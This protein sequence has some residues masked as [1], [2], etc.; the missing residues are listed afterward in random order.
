MLNSY[1]KGQPTDTPL[2]P[3]GSTEAVAERITGRGAV[4]RLFEQRWLVLLLGLILFALAA[5]YRLPWEAEA[6]ALAAFVAGAALIPR[7]AMKQVFLP[8]IAAPP[9]VEP[10]HIAAL[11][12]DA[13]P[14]PTIL[15]SCDGTILFAN[16][17]ARDLFGGLRPGS[18][19]SSATRSPQV[20][21]AVMDCGPAEAQRTVTF[22]ER[23]PVERYMAATVSYLGGR[24]EKDA[25]I[26]LFLRDLTEQRRLDQL[27]SDFIANAS[28]EIKTPL[29]SVIGFIETL[30]GAARHDEAARDRFLPIMA[31]QA[32]RMA[33]LI[34]NLMSLSRVEMRAHL[35]PRDAVA[36]SEL[37]RHVCDTLEPMACEAGIDIQVHSELDGVQVLGDRDELT[38]VFI[39]LIHNAIKYGRRDGSVRVSLE[40]EQNGMIAITSRGRWPGH[41]CS[42]FATLDGALLSGSGVGS[43]GERRHRPWARHRQARGQ[44]PPGRASHL[45]DNRLGLQILR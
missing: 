10:T 9:P 38:Q 24:S 44:P 20:L 27:R 5:V 8:P 30:Q 18:H 26:L 23:V 1:D 40:R 22:S 41:R 4:A 31:R 16:G 2:Y 12:I 42:A 39:N 21:D 36:I 7:A 13:L 28:H 11:V 3:A 45:V 37:V 6:A 15:L 33:R 17:K 32:E 35:K 19:I 14:E 29:A 43:D 34:D 25:S